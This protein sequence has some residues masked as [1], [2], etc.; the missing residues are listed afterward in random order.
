MFPE[1][2]VI[3]VDISPTAVKLCQVAINDAEIHNLKFI[4]VDFFDSARGV[5]LGHFDLIF[6]HTFFCA[7]RP[8]IRPRWAERIKSLLSADSAYLLA[9]IY[10]LPQQQQKQEANSNTEG[11]PFE[12]TFESYTRIL[13]DEMVCCARWTSEQVPASSE[14]RRGREELALWQRK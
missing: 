7:I 4:E 14:R 13:S 9:I 3:G 1:A 5:D 2:E 11:P 12:V 8:E 10:P 6:D